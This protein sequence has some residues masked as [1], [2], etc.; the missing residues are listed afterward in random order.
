VRRLR[1]PLSSPD[2]NPNL[3]N[4]IDDFEDAYLRY[5]EADP[6]DA[7]NFASLVAWMERRGPLR[8]ARLLDVGAGS[9]KLVRRFLAHGTIA[10]GLEPS[11]S[12][13]DRFLAGD[14]RSRAGCSTSIVSR[15]NGSTW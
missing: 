4:T 8:G 5:L 10:E 11:R 9:G 3:A 1:I 12:L 2:V 6:S 14:P 13:F 15:A 7:A